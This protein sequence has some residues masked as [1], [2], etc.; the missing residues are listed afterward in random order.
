MALAAYQI[1]QKSTYRFKI[2]WGKHKTDDLIS[3]LTFLGSRL[4]IDQLQ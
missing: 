4:K 2:Y 1:S 3:L